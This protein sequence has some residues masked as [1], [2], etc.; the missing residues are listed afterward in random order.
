MPEVHKRLN[1]LGGESKPTSSEDFARWVR[2]EI[3]RWNKVAQ[4]AGIKPQ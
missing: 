2:S 1:E 4:V 3:D